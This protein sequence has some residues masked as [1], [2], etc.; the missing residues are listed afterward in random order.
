[1]AVDRNSPREPS[2]GPLLKGVSAERR[3]KWRRQEKSVSKRL[4]KGKESSASGAT[5][6]SKGDARSKKHL[7]ECKRTDKDSFRLT[8]EVLD[9]I[10][11]EAVKV[12]REPVVQL[13]IAGREYAVILWDHFVERCQ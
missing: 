3:T 12:G 4:V 5:W 2:L 11:I 7:V 10:R 6:A 9:K 13:E 1:M 8:A